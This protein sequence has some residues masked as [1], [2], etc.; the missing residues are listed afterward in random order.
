MMKSTGN[1]S[2]VAMRV[3]VKC[4]Q[5]AAKRNVQRNAQRVLPISCLAS[6]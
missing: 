1:E 3:C 4:M 6:R 2:I 5:S